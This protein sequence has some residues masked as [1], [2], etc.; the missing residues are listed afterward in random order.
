[1]RGLPHYGNWGSPMWTIGPATF[2]S[3][4]SHLVT[5]PMVM[6]HTTGNLA[7][8]KE[9]K[10]QATRRAGY[11]AARSRVPGSLDCGRG[12]S[13]AQ[14]R[15]TAGKRPVADKER[16]FPGSCRACTLQSVQQSRNSRG[17]SI[18]EARSPLNVSELHIVFSSVEIYTNSHAL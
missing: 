9:P 1:M 5:L 4:C 6:Y 14:V 13:R 18:P 17:C 15:H 7:S 12:A 8:H 16:K 10:G 2:Q 3:K 11:L